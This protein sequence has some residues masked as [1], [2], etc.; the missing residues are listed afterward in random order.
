MLKE[1]MESTK[2]YFRKFAQAMRPKEV[3]DRP[4]KCCFGHKPKITYVKGIGLIAECLDGT[5]YRLIPR[6]ARRTAS[7]TSY[8]WVRVT[9]HTASRSSKQVNK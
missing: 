9:S 2:A 1:V 3:E 8:Q 5:K 7:G 4:S 6:P